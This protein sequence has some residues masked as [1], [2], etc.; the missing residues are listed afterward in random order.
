MKRSIGVRNK[1]LGKATLICYIC[2]IALSCSRFGSAETE[3]LEEMLSLGVLIEPGGDCAFIRSPG[4]NDFQVEIRPFHASGCNTTYF[5]GV[6]Y[7]AYVNRE[8]LRLIQ[9]EAFLQE[10]A[11]SACSATITGIQ[12]LISSPASNPALINTTDYSQLVGFQIVDG[13]REG[14][15]RAESGLTSA[16]FSAADATAEI[17][18]ARTPSVAEYEANLYMP[19]AVVLAGSF[20]EAGCQTAIYPTLNVRIPGWMADTQVDPVYTSAGPYSADPVIYLGRCVFGSVN[21]GN[22]QFCA[23]LQ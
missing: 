10:T 12:G 17:S 6:D 22:P 5:F 11:P 3:S 18:L 19:L 14:R 7:Q 1:I 15:G 9:A 20:G 13:P 21:S 16:G 2:L 23:T 8:R 4:A